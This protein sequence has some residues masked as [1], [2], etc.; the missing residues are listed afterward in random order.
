MLTKVVFVL[1]KIQWK[2]KYCEIILSFRFFLYLSYFNKKIHN[3]ITFINYWI[4]II[5]IKKCDGSIWWENVTLQDIS[6][7]LTVFL[8]KYK[9]FIQIIHS[10]NMLWF[11]P[12]KCLLVSVKPLIL[13]VKYIYL[14]CCFIFITMNEK[15]VMQ[16]LKDI[17]WFKYKK[18]LFVL[19]FVCLFLV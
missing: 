18:R 17:F 14:N 11:D 15:D 4:F 7:S 6:S 2:R 19:L 13:I 5:L 1:S 12:L 10:H 8:E 16:K 9:E 3:K